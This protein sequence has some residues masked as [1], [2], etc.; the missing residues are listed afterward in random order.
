MV[1]RSTKK[2]LGSA[3]LGADIPVSSVPRRRVE[4][5]ADVYAN[6]ASAVAGY[7]DLAIVFSE[8][9]GG[10]DDKPIVLEKCRVSMNPAHG[11]ALALV[12]A[13]TVKRWENTFGEIKLPPGM[14]ATLETKSPLKRLP[15]STM[16]LEKG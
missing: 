12:L 16:A 8:I 15:A 14:V 5:F 11:K 13:Q 1:A 6:N 2:T 9:Q 7:Y 4:G 10:S 3:G